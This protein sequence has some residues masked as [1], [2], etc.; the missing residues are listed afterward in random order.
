MALD[1]ICFHPGH[2]HAYSDSEYAKSITRH[3]AYSESGSWV[4]WPIGEANSVEP[5]SCLCFLWGTATH[6]E[7]CA[8]NFDAAQVIMRN[9]VCKGTNTPLCHPL[10]VSEP[11]CDTKPYYRLLVGLYVA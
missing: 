5:K 4:A 8:Q 3:S 6:C 10:Y 2:K 11:S 1:D 9:G 7:V